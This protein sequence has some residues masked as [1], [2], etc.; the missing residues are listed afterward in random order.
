MV[1]NKKKKDYDE[2]H[3]ALDEKTQ[4]IQWTERL[5]AS[6]LWPLGNFLQPF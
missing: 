4:P 6:S 3:L 5:D 1:S 2:P